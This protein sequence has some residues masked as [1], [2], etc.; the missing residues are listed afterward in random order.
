MHERMM[1]PS[2]ETKASWVLA[3]VVLVILA[4]SF[5]APWIAIVALKT[6]AAETGGQRSV[7][8]LATSLAWLGFGTG[9]IVMGYVAER[10]GVRWTVLFGAVMICLGLMLSTRGATWQLYV[11]QGLFVGFLGIGG[12]NSPFYVYVSHWFDRHRGSAL[13]LISSGGYFAGAIWPPVFERAISYWSWQQTMIFY[14]LL[15]AAVIIPL[16]AIFLRPPPEQPD[17]ADL[18]GKGSG[19][20]SVLGWPP[21]LVFVLVAM[22]V[23]FCCIPMAMPQAHLPAF[24]S[25]LGILASHGAAMVSVLLGTA[26]VSRQFWGWVSDRIGG[27]KTV[28]VGSA[29]QILAMTAFMLTQDE[30]GLFTV[31]AAFGL[32]F[33][34]II[35][36]YIL[37]IRELFPPSEAYWRIPGFLLCSGTG[38]ALGGWLAG[39]LYDHFGSYVW[40]FGA[41]VASNAVN[42]LIVGTLVARGRLRSARDI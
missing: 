41:G 18:L 12:M 36:A 40:A 32:G 19:P 14:G 30:V 20:R 4:M 9:G 5:G 29:F 26:F 22:A 33:A 17:H 21:N 37:A 27:L 23:I 7:P 1:L 15:E 2:V 42:L 8:A 13:A 24:C 34:G 25:D 38:M 28:L 31:A 10:V 11:G 16:A 3:G 35:P 39:V 6:I